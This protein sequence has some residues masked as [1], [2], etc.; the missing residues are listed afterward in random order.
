[1]VFIDLVITVCTDGEEMSK[2]RIGEQ[3]LQQVK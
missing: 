3:V 1:M 2:V